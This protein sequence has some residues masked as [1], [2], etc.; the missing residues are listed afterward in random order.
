[1]D[2]SNTTFFFAEIRKILRAYTDYQS[3]ALKEYGLSPNEIVVLSSIGRVGLASE[4]AASSNSSKAL[5]SRSVKS[6]KEKG[7]VTATISDVDKREQ[8]LVLTESGK[9]MSATIERINRKFYATAFRNFDD[10]EKQVLQALLKLIL[11]NL[12]AGDADEI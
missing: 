9:K 2:I 7:Y 12:A 8:V 6:L 10:N 11:K 4:I 3:D 5:V 1:M